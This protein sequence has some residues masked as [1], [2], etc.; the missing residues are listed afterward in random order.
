MQCS[1]ASARRL[2]LLNAAL[3]WASMIGLVVFIET[4]MGNVKRRSRQRVGRGLALAVLLGAFQLG[5]GG[6]GDDAGDTTPP[7]PLTGDAIVEI[8]LVDGGHHSTPP[9][10]PAGF[11]LLDI[12]LNEGT[13]GNY[14][15]L[16]YRTG[17]A[18]GAD[19]QPVSRIYTVDEFDGETLQ[20]GVQLPVNLNANE[21]GGSNDQRL[22]LAVVKA[23]RP[24]ARCVVVENRTKSK[25][26]YG[27]PEAAGKYRIEWVRELS[28]DQWGSPYSD[29][30]FDTQDLNEGESF[31]PY[32]ISDYIHIGTCKD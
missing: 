10:A 4:G 17:R 30:P 15:W 7:A 13:G 1:E 22:W 5:C 19:G 23:D 8:R 12:D 14:I 26:V 28:P 11:R 3:P 31:P 16:Y 24:V 32:F 9:A 6:G 25:R 18:D 27:P 21:Y 29:L 2:R 20:Q